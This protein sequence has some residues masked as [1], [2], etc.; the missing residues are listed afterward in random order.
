MVLSEI[1]KPNS[2]AS[3]FLRVIEVYSLIILLTHIRKHETGSVCNL[4]FHYIAHRLN[5]N[6]LYVHNFIETKLELELKD[7]LLWNQLMKIMKMQNRELR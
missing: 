2:L 6:H 7:M 1:Q 3:I 4:Q 5:L